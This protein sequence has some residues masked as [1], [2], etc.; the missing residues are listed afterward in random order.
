M[1]SVLSYPQAS[2]Y[3]GMPQLSLP[4]QTDVTIILNGFRRGKNLDAQLNALKRQTV[5]PADIMLWY[6]APSTG[7][8]S[9]P[10]YNFGAIRHTKAAVSN[11]NW[12]VWARFYYALNVRT[13]YVCIFDDD[14]IPG[15][16]WLENCLHT[17]Q[18]HRGL[19]G[20]IG[21]VFEDAQDYYQ[22]TRYGWANPIE[23]PVQVDIVGHAWFFEKAFLTAYCREL[24]L[25]DVQLCGEDIHFSYTLQKYMQLPTWVPPH[26]K[27]AP[28]FWGSTH[29][30]QLGTDAHAISLKHVKKKRSLQKPDD[31]FFTGVNQYYRACQA[32]GWELLQFPNTPSLASPLII[33]EEE[34]SPLC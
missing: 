3:T 12:G 20:S 30:W 34:S 17:I 25:L 14:T 1:L 33:P 18:T 27:E 7:L 32:Q 2:L 16:R 22:H 11:H 23:T 21:L 31:T 8:A 19:L 9:L 10:K 4:A 28:E 5:P 13:T 29:G 6:N 24:P 26:P 15:P